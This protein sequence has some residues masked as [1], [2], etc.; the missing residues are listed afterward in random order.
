MS[1]YKDYAERELKVLGYDMDDTEEGPNKWMVESIMELLDVFEKQGHSGSSASH[2]IQLFSKVT[3][4]KPLAPLTG[5]DSEWINTGLSSQQNNRCSH[6]FKGADGRAYDIQGKVFREPNG[7]CFTNKESKVYVKF[8]Y[9]PK[10][11]YVDVEAHVEK[12]S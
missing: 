11:E 3:L 6:V 10:T 8:P 5:E 2:C 7:V 4:F 1:N 9:T 12:E